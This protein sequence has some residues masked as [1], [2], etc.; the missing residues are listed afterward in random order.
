MGAKK[1]PKKIKSEIRRAEKKL[2]RLNEK[3][4]KAEYNES[5]IGFKF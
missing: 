1:T 2:E 3:L 4:E 5:R